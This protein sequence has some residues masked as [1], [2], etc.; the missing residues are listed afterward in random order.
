MDE[1]ALF[2][3]ER[4]GCSEPAALLLLKSAFITEVIEAIPMETLRDRLQVLVD[5]RL[6]GELSKCEGCKLCK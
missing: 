5:K 1:A 2:D 4:R 3:V 6:R